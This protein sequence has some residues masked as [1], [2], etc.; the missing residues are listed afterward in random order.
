MCCAKCAAQKVLV[1]VLLNS[2]GVCYV[3]VKETITTLIGRLR[4]EVGHSFILPGKC[5]ANNLKF[6]NWRWRLK[7]MISVM[8]CFRKL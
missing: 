3:T 5:P 4:Y 2:P 8:L 6:L 7:E 1:D